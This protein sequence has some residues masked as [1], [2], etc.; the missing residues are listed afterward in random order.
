MLHGPN[1]VR[2][3]VNL[4]DKK[5]SKK[6]KI[7]LKFHECTIEDHASF[8]PPTKNYEQT[9]L[10]AQAIYKLYCIDEAQDLRKDVEG[11]FMMVWISLSLRLRNQNFKWQSLLSN[12]LI[13]VVVKLCKIKM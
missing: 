13:K 11:L 5:I 10:R 1:F 12:N 6:V 3:E 7:P 2:F 4:V 9:I 8:Y